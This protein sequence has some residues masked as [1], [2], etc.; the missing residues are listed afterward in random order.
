MA[1]PV[2]DGA[3]IDAGL[4]KM[5]SRAAAHTVRVDAFVLQRWHRLRRLT[6][7][8]LENEAGSKAREWPPAMVAKQQLRFT[9]IQPGVCDVLF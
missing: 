6:D 7:M 2:G 3:Q 4:E 8:A 9:Q 5:D 1:Q